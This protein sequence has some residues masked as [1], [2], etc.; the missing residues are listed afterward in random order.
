MSARSSAPRSTTI[1]IAA[2]QCTPRNSALVGVDRGAAVVLMIESVV[3][4][5]PRSEH[6]RKLVLVY[7]VMRHFAADLRAAGW[8]IDYYAEHDALESALASHVERLRP[9][10]LRMMQQ[11]EWGITEAM[12]AAARAAGLDVEV[13]P[14]A[15]FVS[16]PADF[17]GLAKTDSARVTLDIFYR[18]MRRKTGLLM[19]GGQP[20]GG[21]WNFDAKNRKRPQPGLRFAPVPSFEPD[22]ITRDVIAFVERRFADHPGVVGDF[23]LAVTRRDALAALEHF[24][25]Q[26]LDTFGP[27]QDAMI[28]GERNMSHSLLSAYINTGLLHPLE[29]CARAELAYRDGTARLESVEG[30]IRQVIGWR[31]YVWRVYWKM[32]P[33]YR[34]RNAL[35]AH[36]PLPAFY[37]TG[38]TDL[39][40][41]RE[42][43]AHV[44]ETAYAHHILRLMVLGNFALLAGCDPIET[45][46]WFWAMFIDGYDWVMV[47]NVIGMALHADGGYVG[48]KPYCA[49]ANYINTMSD[50]CKR[51]RYDQKSIV[52][53]D[54]CP[55]NALYWD[56]IARNEARFSRNTRMAV[57]VRNWQ[58]RPESWRAAVRAKAQRITE[59]LSRGEPLQF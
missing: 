39:F 6:K 58:R 10:R 7:A 37:W 24:C 46:D 31:E 2:D 13:T 32:M 16:E 23:R 20:A 34:E 53:D 59:A 22:A 21:A 27:W 38:E 41:L 33:A 52:T 29:V 12:T 50:Y 25:A 57:I 3:R 48:T 36:L 45:N 42:A 19:D 14:H 49:S 9:A 1:W 18:A 5:S 28:A 40:C 44:R 17:D 30:F 54:A 11:S 4:A 51:C 26:R 47:P 43:L 35:G 15:N 56:F 55:F 8:T